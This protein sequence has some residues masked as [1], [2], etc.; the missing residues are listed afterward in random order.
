MSMKKNEGRD[1]EYKNLNRTVKRAVANFKPP[2]Q[3]TVTEWADKYRRLSPE[4]SAEAGPW[5]TSRTPYLQEIMDA[6]TDP[7]IHRIVVT[8]SSQVGKTEME[9]N[10]IGYMMDV[11]PGPAMWVLPTVDNGKDFSKRR[12]A[13]MIRDTKP[14]RKKVALSKSRDSDNTLLKKV[15][16][17]GMLTITGSNSS[18]SLA[19][20]PCRYVFGDERDRWAKDAGGEGDPWGLVEARTITF[21]NYKMVEVSTPTIKGHSAIEKSFML[22]TQ[23]YWSVECPHCHEFNYIEFEHIHYEAHKIGKGK[24]KQY[25]VDKIEYC[26]PSCGCVS[27]EN[28]I[29][30]QP[31]K[32]IAKNWD[33]IR[34]GIRSF[35]INAFTS[36]WLSWERI[37]LKYLEAEG[38]IQ[39]LKTVYNT[40]FGKLW[41]EQ[42]ETMDED[43]FLKRRE[44]YKA[45]LPDGV[46]CLTCGVDTQD[47]RL[48]YEVVGYGMEKHNW[49]IDKGIIYGKPS[50][51]NV[52]ERLDGIVDR[53]WKFENGK[54]IK[55]SVTFVDS[56]G[57]Y[58]QEVYEN[59]RKRRFK[60]VFAIKGRSEEGIPYISP[61]GKAK[62]VKKG[63]VIGTT[64]LFIIGVDA[65]KEN[66]MSG[67][68][69]ENENI[70]RY[71]FPLNEERGYDSNYFN[72]L[73]SENKVFVE[74]LRGGKWKWVKLPGHNRN[75]AL[76]CRNYANAAYRAMNPNLE[77]LFQKIHEIKPKKKIPGTGRRKTSHRISNDDW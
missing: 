57:H 74:T 59:C 5:R 16:P 10:M 4:N 36:P 45:E 75:E 17:G 24:E 8:A 72:G 43:D 39:Q 50:E 1:E 60:N 38:D 11:D 73:L 7:K 37:I 14:L 28:E 68:M 52:W 18:A 41:N 31:K 70:H 13:P 29:K 48:E 21:Y 12:M 2:E 25:L 23:E 33:A 42:L 19:S 30:K 22:G 9:M 53:K 34:N 56:G 20:V 47:D 67:L 66:I 64:P 51:D 40:L 46:L 65:G 6:F 27:G 71:H 54:G 61:P 32:W 77:K 76:D 15:Y 3:L 63:V 55:I 62:I 58:T 44:E 35:W 49:G 26:C 69:M